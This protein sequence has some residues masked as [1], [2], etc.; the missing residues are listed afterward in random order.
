MEEKDIKDEVNALM[1]NGLFDAAEQLV[2][3][4]SMD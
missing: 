1:T 3:N 2:I 4:I